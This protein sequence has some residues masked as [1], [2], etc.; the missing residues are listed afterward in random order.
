MGDGTTCTPSPKLF[1]YGPENGDDQLPTELS[2][3]A[4][5]REIDVPL[6]LAI[7]FKNDMIS[8]WFVSND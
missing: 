2:N 1:P 3:G 6:S 4:A 7:K 5:T 8:K